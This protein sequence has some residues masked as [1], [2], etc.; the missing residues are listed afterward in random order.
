VCLP[1]KRVKRAAA[2]NGEPDFSGTVEL[3]TRQQANQASVGLAKEIGIPRFIF[4]RRRQEAIFQNVQ[5]CAFGFNLFENVIARLRLC[6]AGNCGK[7]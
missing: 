1:R 7:K 2:A 6:E 4:F 5:F 3:L